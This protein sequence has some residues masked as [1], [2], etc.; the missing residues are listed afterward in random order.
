DL[1]WGGWGRTVFRASGLP[2]DGGRAPA[3]GFD[4]AAAFTQEAAASAAAALG[5]AGEAEL[6]DGVW[7]VG[8]RDGS[9]A[10]VTLYPDGTASFNYYDPAKDPW[11]CVGPDA[12]TSGDASS[13]GPATSGAAGEG[14]SGA[15]DLTEPSIALP[16]PQPCGDRDLGQAPRGEAA[17][18]VVRDALTALGLDPAGFELAAEDYGDEMWTYVNAHQV[19]GGQRT[20][21]AWSASLT[22]GGLQSLYGPLAPAVE[23]GEYDV[24]SP[25]EAVER[26]GDPRFGS[27][28]SGPVRLLDGE[29]GAMAEMPAEPTTP[30]L[31]TTPE[32]GAPFAWPV[33]EVTIVDVR[34]GS[35]LHTLPDGA[36]ALLP[37]YELISGDGAV[38]TVLAVAESALDLEPS[39]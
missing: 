31:P 16:E 9:A 37:T 14:S 8:P 7:T 38:W 15:A 22:G 3:W 1:A 21:L 26:L 35:A 18:A 4:P 12:P 10:G 5:V 36:A 20:G 24:V 30:Q 33:T 25:T 23:L 2:T 27:G 11:A 39:R 29:P 6:V 28:G 19:V 32:A 34:L 17:V 13:S